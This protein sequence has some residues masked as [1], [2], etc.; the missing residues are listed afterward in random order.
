MS[1]VLSLPPQ[2]TDLTIHTVEHSL[3]PADGELVIMGGQ[4]TTM[5]PYAMTVLRA[6]ID[7]AHRDLP[8][9]AMVGLRHDG[10]PD[11]LAV[12]RSVVQQPSQL[13][14]LTRTALDAYIARGALRRGRRLLGTGLSFPYLSSL[15]VDTLVPGRVEAVLSL[16]KVEFGP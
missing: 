10:T 4:A 5:T 12:F 6:V 15:V 13:S 14:A 8:P 16:P 11:V 3:G 2:I 7:A 1:R 9:A